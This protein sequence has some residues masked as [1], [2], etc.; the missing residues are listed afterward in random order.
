[1]KMRRGFT[2]IELLVVISIIGVLVAL[3]LPAVQ[4]AREAARRAQCSNNL[5]Q[6]GLA[7]H[8]YHDT[9]NKLPASAE[10]AFGGQAG[11]WGIRIIPYLEQRTLYDSFNF[12]W[13]FYRPPNHTVLRTVVGTY[14]CPTTPRAGNPTNGVINNSSG[15]SVADPNVFGASG[16][17]F[18]ARSYVDLWN[19]P[20]LNEHFGAIEM[21]KYT[22]FSAVLD[23]LSNTMLTYECAGKPDYY[24]RHGLVSAYSPSDP[25]PKS[26]ASGYSH[27][28]WAGFMNMRIVSF[29]GGEYEYDGA[30]VIN[31]HN[32]WNGLYS[33]H[34]GGNNTLACDGSVRFL[35]ESTPKSILKAYVSRAEGEVISSDA[36]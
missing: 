36:F 25:Q 13:A 3:L 34:P 5:K 10:P 21:Y 7:F 6:I 15:K 1:M 17:Y 20:T 14:V 28:L 16:D 11:G 22:S 19:V 12:N 33:F 35:K 26:Q 24:V 4:S 9:F 18:T 23:G 27:G 29:T 8:S 2:L 32:G 30:C 31:C